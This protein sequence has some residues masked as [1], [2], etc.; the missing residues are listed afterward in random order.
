METTHQTIY[1]VIKSTG[2]SR[3][4]AVKAIFGL[5]WSS[6]R[7]CAREIGASH[8]AVRKILAGEIRGGTISKRLFAALGIDNP[9]V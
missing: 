1:A 5:R 4:A 6:I 2:Y 3:C 7:A 9:W 8:T